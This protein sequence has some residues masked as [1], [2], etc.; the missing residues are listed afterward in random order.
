MSV[1]FVYPR[2]KKSLEAG[3]KKKKKVKRKDQ[4]IKNKEIRMKYY[5][6]IFTQLFEKFSRL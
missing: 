1:Q 4:E 6:F 5:P 3:A 2:N